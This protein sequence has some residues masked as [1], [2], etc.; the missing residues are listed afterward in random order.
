MKKHLTSLLTVL[1]LLSAVFSMAQKFSY[2]SVPGDPMNTRIY[3]LSNGLKVYL[4]VYKESPRI[5][6]A[7]AVR[8]GSKNDPSDNT[9]LSHYLEHMMFK[10]TTHFG[11][12]DY[13]QEAPLL[14][15]IEELFEEYRS[16]ADEA[17]RSE[18]YSRI[19][20][21]AGEAANFAIA[22]E[23]DKLVSVIGAKGTN[24]FTG[25][26][27][28]VYINDIP[29]NEIENW[30][31]IESDR[32]ANPV[33]RL[34]HTELET[35]YEEKN[36]SLD[37]DGDKLWEAM[38][39]G[40]YAKHPY[41]TQTTIGTIDHLK[42]PSLKRLKQYYNERYVAGNMALIMAGDLNPDSTIKMIDKYFKVLDKKKA[43]HF[44]SP[45]EDPITA[46]IE[47]A[48][49]GP[50]AE[51]IAIGFRCGGIHTADANLL[52]ITAEVLSNGKAGLI[53]LNLNLAQKVLS[54]SAGTDI[55]TDY[56]SLIL[57]GKPKDKQSLE[58]VKDLLLSQIEALKKGEFPDWLIP[59]IITNRKLSKVK[60]LES[61]MS[62]AM[63]LASVFVMEQPYEESVKEI[64]A[65]SKIT[66]QQIIDFANRTLSNNYVVVYK[67]I[68]EDENVQKVTK[69]QITPVTMHRDNESQFYASV[70]SAPVPDIKPV[71]L[72][73]GVDIKQ[74]KTGKKGLDFLYVPNKEN[75]LF[76]LYY[77]FAMGSQNDLKLA[78][79]VN[80]LSFL[81][82]SKYTAEQLKQ[83]F[84]KLGCSYSVNVSND[85]IY[86]NLTGL[87]EN[88]EAAMTLLESLL[89]DAQPNAE[90][91]E[92]LVSDVLKSRSD[93]KL[94]KNIIRQAL[95]MYG[96]YGPES[97]FT[98]I[99]SE[100]QLKALKA[101][102]LVSI[103]HNLCS[104]QHIVLYYGP[105]PLNEST[106]IRPTPAKSK[107]ISYLIDK[108][109]NAGE[110][111]KP[112]PDRIKY[113]QLPTEEPKV[114]VVDYNMKQADIVFLSKSI[115][116]S[117]KLNPIIR[118]FNEYFG[119]GMNSIVFQEIRE[120]KA[121]AYSSTASFR[122]PAYP[123]ENYSI[124]AFV[125][126]Q[127]DKM[128]EALEAMLALFNKMP[129]SEKSFASAKEGILN[130]IS[131]ERITKSRIL[132]N[133]INARKFGF[134]T[135]M[136]K[137]IYAKIPTMTFGEVL[138]FQQNYLKN[139][140]FTILVVGNTK[141][142][143]LD[144]LAKYGKIQ[145]LDLT[146]IFG[147]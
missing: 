103:I 106:G 109:H 10:G 142:M 31:K 53:D 57:T 97:S 113:P 50:D 48:V 20:K 7:I 11:T 144:T 18:I 34:F 107:D 83:E 70:A 134:D 26:E 141:K 84:Y 73:Y 62:R 72:N 61:N 124:Y 147:Y 13:S 3:T 1:F 24:A 93:N 8:T 110:N 12:S 101:D 131:T 105:L 32:F 143:D 68:G 28:T 45:V 104:F 129:E 64:E 35:V 116:Y 27:Q 85:E 14:E 123:D 139:K 44:V 118:M 30:L 2:E 130:Q 19:D 66:K 117:P 58:E 121:L 67:R 133:Y 21:I 37:R 77:Y 136:R 78:T 80:Y 127:N 125:G 137:E 128:P 108:Y 132:F 82:T 94:N 43:V 49:F 55:Q 138:E 69:P 15:Q 115:S 74:G 99:L 90:A 135:D 91:L 36:M 96:T 39:A 38:Y 59:A 9:G 16:T 119:S 46:P 54:A 111:R 102:E 47:K 4:T 146:Q 114:F 95:S 89:A 23:Y 40:L 42:N 5:Q 17:A 75:N 92:N 86:V 140:Q 33:F 52:D 88:M 51:N 6:T 126:T 81:G 63:N 65:L 120:A 25:N 87:A 112:V 98:H 145:F 22:N 76:S 122:T 79:A 41:G 60:Q 56:S 71:F 29:A 100:S